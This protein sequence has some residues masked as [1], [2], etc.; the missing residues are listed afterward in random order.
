[1]PAFLHANWSHISGNVSFQLLL[2]S[3]IEYGIG[4]WWMAFLYIVSEIGGVLLCIT[5]RPEMY[6]IGASC[7]GFGLIGYY[8]SYLFTNFDFMGRKIR[9]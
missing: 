4:F 7:A 5:L 3:G 6:G 8:L 2:G 1:M 9:G